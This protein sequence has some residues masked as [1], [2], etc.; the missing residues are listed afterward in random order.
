MLGRTLAAEGDT[1]GAVHAFVRMREL[2]ATGAPD[3]L[4]LAVAVSASRRGSP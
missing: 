1:P 2:V 4:G 3:P